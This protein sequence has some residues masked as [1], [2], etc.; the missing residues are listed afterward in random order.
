MKKFE[1]A[2]AEVAVEEDEVRKKRH[3]KNYRHEKIDQKLRKERTETEQ[4]LM[5]EAEK[6]GVKI[7]NVEQE[8]EDELVMDKVEGQPLKQVVEEQPEIM[9]ELGKNLALLHDT[10]IVHGDLTTSNSVVDKKLFLIDFGLS[11]RSK[12]TEDKAVDIHLLKQV[13][14]SSHPEV[15]DEAWQNF[16]KAY[17]QYEQSEEVLEQLKDVESRGRYK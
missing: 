15:A 6:H 7:P 10:G 3:P 1:G 17:S 5:E 16:V 14:N 12:R 8:S 11:F 13:L 4:H 9:E 2:E